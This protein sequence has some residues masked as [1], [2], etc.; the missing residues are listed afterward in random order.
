MSEKGTSEKS[1][2]DAEAAYRRRALRREAQSEFVAL[3]A[4]ARQSGE[5]TSETVARLRRQPAA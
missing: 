5:S 2:S 4:D 3:N 1:E